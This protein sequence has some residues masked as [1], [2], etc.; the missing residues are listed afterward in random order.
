MTRKTR[1]EE[2]VS[3]ELKEL[4]YIR[5]LLILQLTKAGA[6]QT[7]IGAALGVDQSAVSRMMPLKGPKKKAK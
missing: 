2:F 1:K 4:T 5:R 7:E 3:E 6:T